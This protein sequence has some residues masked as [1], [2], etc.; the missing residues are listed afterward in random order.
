MGSELISARQPPIPCESCGSE[1]APG[2]LSCPS[3]RKL[4]YSTRLK[5]LAQAAEASEKAGDVSAVL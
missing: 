1:V 3:C 5:E 2:L 4:I